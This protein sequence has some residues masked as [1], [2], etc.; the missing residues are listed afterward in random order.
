L[1]QVLFAIGASLRTMS[2]GT[3]RVTSLYGGTSWVRDPGKTYTGGAVGA[4]TPVARVIVTEHVWVKGGE[5]VSL[6]DG[7]ANEGDVIRCDEPVYD[8]KP[9]GFHILESGPNYARLSA[10]TGTLTGTKYIH[11]MRDIT[12]TVSAEGDDVNVKEAWLVS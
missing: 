4:G 7:A 5:E 11:N 2:D 10:G 6:F 3:L 8:L 12:R 1:T 9:V